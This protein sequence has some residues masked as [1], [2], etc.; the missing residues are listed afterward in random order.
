MLDADGAEPI[1]PGVPL[2]SVQ[3]GGSLSAAVMSCQTPE[4]MSIVEEME[5]RSVAEETFPEN[6]RRAP[7]S[8]HEPECLK[9]TWF[10]C[11]DLERGEV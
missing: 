7:R 10:N 4:I 2:V 1:K 6:C 8:A 5:L 9:C 11:R 3:P